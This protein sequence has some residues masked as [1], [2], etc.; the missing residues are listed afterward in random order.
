MRT[1]YGEVL[2]NLTFK[3]IKYETRLSNRQVAMLRWS[4]IK[5]D[6]IRTT[7]MRDCKISREVM[8]AL[9]L[10][11]HSSS[12][13][14]VFFGNSLSHE[15]IER[16]GELERQLQKPKRRFVIMKSKEMHKRIDKRAMVC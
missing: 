15:E 16:L 11:P 4:Q 10:L 13:D 6:T 8:D 7:R 14:L 9:A 1:A 2:R 12:V 3:T 5:G